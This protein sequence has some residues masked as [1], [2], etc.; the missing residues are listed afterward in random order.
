MKKFT[1]IGE[2]IKALRS[3]LE[4]GATQKEFS[5]KVGISERMLRNIENANAA[6]PA[7]IVDALARELGVHRR[8]LVFALDTPQLVAE[9]TTASEAIPMSSANAFLNWEKDQ[10]VPRFDDDLASVTMDEA[11]LFYEASHSHDVEG[12]IQVPLNSETGAYV[13][14]LIEMLTRLSYSKRHLFEKVGTVEEIDIRKQIRGLLVLLKGNDVWV[15]K[16]HIFRTLPESDVLQ[17]DDVPSEMRSRLYV[18]VGQPGE[19]GE[20]TVRVKVDHGQPFVLK[21]WK[22]S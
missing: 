8:E 5:H 18:A 19:Y 15:Y 20:E 16:T 7:K 3:Q 21:A 12:V 6:V 22:S 9:G 10:L 1:P 4:R 13:A 17:P 11:K 14:E 2:K